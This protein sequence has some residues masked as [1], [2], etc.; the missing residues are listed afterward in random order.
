MDSAPAVTTERPACP[1]R[2][3][4]VHSA[5]TSWPPRVAVVL[6]AGHGSRMG[7]RRPLPKPL[8]K[9]AGLGLLER[10]L[11]TLRSAGIEQFRVVVGADRQK[12]S[13]HV[14][15]LAAQH[16]IQVEVV[17][18]DDFAAGNGASLAAGARGLDEGFLVAMADHVM[19][20]EFA[21][22]FLSRAS[23]RPGAPQV[24]ADAIEAV[25]DLDDATKLRTIDGRIQA[26]GKDLTSYGSVDAGLFYFP[27]GAAARIGQLVA[28]GARSVSD[29]VTGIAA[30]RPFFAV[31]VEAGVWQDVDTSAMAREAERRLLRSLAKSTDGF[32]S[33]H[34]NRPISIAVSRF[35]ARWGVRPNTITTIVS[36]ISLVGA[37]LVATAD[38][39]WLAI[40]GLL[41][42]IASILDGCDGEVA[43]L[44]YQGSR[45][46]AWYD[47]L[48]DNVRYMV[49]YA[50]LGVAA[51][52]LSGSSAYLW[53]LIPFL[54]LST[55]FVATMARYVLKTQNHLT[56]LAV[57]KKVLGASR[58]H[59]WER[60]VLPLSGLIKQD[61]QAFI[62]MVFCLI[63]MPG[64]YFW[65]TVLG[66]VLMTVSVL[67]ALG[68]EGK[69]GARA[70]VFL[71]YSAGLL[72]LAALVSRMP[73]ESIEEA[74]RGVG[75]GVVLAF[76]AAPLW[77]AANAFG[78]GLL[79]G[80]RVR[81]RHLFYNQVVGEAMNTIV[82]LAG[83]GGDLFRVRH[84][85]EFVG[86]AAATRAVV[87]DRLVHALS[88]PLFAG[89][90]IGLTLW[91]V[92][93]DP[94]L[95]AGL[96]A[97]AAVLL[98]A[99][100]ALLGFA[101]TPYPTRWSAALLRRLTGSSAEQIESLPRKRIAALL[102]VKM[103]GRMLNLVEIAIILRLLGLEANA[104]LV[105]AI[106]GLLSAS[107]VVFFM[108]P[109]GLGV[110]EAGIAGAFSMLGLAASSGLAFGL[111]RRARVVTWAGIGLALQ[112]AAWG[113]K[114]LR[115]R[116]PAGAVVAQ[117]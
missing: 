86:T 14:R 73:L 38:P 91:M 110:N 60:L 7:G 31:K 90:A 63:G 99:G 17:D 71:F 109:Q 53:A 11:L 66:S 101:L 77:Y 59:W 78:I 49:F 97:T 94:G 72:L 24:A 75:A 117:S 23:A 95:T 10:S 51:F 82:P 105:V 83:L 57:T 48:S 55:F 47:T 4:Q 34:I 42:Q 92:P 40:G 114:R 32:I 35:L 111:I 22:D 103:I 46:G 68:R 28:G 104:E 54:A 69:A 26:I 100:L 12:V 112:L 96:A 56:N 9:V 2:W 13:A 102:G 6:A 25:Y 62:A 18:C 45:W 27:A 70:Q 88:G 81:F 37:G 74:F 108:V 106:A 65:V 98:A 20:G 50:A 113:W 33:R 5:A 44:K 29:V 43:R 76:V 39:V 64:P 79:V 41:F 21:R 58:K 30:E 16:G 116:A 87:Q 93:L 36:L 3:S 15:D 67:R 19:D 61:V 8:F 107:A 52:K 89:A 80:G 85:G 115:A 84:L 1:G